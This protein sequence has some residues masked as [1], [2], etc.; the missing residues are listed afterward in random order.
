[1][2]KT[3]SS[4]ILYKNMV[5]SLPT[6]VL[7]IL[8]FTFAS[9][10]LIKVLVTSK[11][12]RTTKILASS[13]C[14]LGTTTLISSTIRALNSLSMLPLPPFFLGCTFTPS[15]NFL[16]LE[17]I[18]LMATIEPTKIA[19]ALAFFYGVSNTPRTELST[20]LDDINELLFKF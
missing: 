14:Q 19:R 12:L 3:K 18:F 1:M 13:Q 5:Q 16:V 8:P 20:E 4:A 7:T 17:F 2:A 6:I 10:I 15:I 11:I 9:H